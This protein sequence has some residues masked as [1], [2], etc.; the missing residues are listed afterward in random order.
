M[1]DLATPK[2]FS[3]SS[4]PSSVAQRWKK[5]LLSFD[6]YLKAVG[7]TKEEQKRALL[8]HVAGEEVLE[9]FNTLTT[10]DS[11]CQSAIDVLTTYF[12]PKAN[13]RYERYL[14]KQCKQQQNETVDTF[15]TRLKR[16]GDT[17]GYVDVNDMI[18]DQVIENSNSHELRKKLLEQS[19]LTLSK[20]Q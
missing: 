12:A 15:V 5:W 7:V 3:V 19:D 11:T 14:F 1:L 6:M 18:V 20:V 10:E 4:D 16:L 8:L 2:K 13:I 9:I 17:C